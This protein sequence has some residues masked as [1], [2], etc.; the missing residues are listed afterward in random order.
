MKIVTYVTPENLR[1]YALNTTEEAKDMVLTEICLE[2]SRDIES[3]CSNRVFYPYKE[4][5]YF[6]HPANRL[7]RWT[8]LKL[9]DDL[10]QV[11]ALTTNEGATAISSGDYF[12]RAG[13]SGRYDEPPYDRIQ[14]EY[15]TTGYNTGFYWSSTPQRANAV[16]GFWGYVPNWG[17]S[18]SSAS[19]WIDSGATISGVTST[20]ITLNS[21]AGVNALGLSPRVSPM[22]LIMWY[23]SDYAD[24]EMGLVTAVDEGTNVLTVQRGVNGTSTDTPTGTPTL[25]V[26]NPPSDIVRATRALAAYY[27]RGRQTSRADISRPIITA[28]GTVIEPSSYPRVITETVERYQ[29]ILE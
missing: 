23:D 11:T 5:K 8:E 10:L 6:D 16:T 17:T 19:C 1:N 29:S 2:A 7:E 26:Y 27:W 28:A 13:F 24:M 25:Y 3:M 12:L 14:L 15:A 18:V 22:S 20:T 21:V 9:K 4:T